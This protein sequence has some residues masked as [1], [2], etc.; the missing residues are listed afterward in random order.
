MRQHNR[1]LETVQ[2]IDAGVAALR[3]TCPIMRHAY[4]LAGTPPL[5]RY[6]PDLRG[7]ARIVVA[8]QVSAASA[9]AIWGR[10]DRAVEYWS[11]NRL[12]ALPTERL[13]ESGLSH[14]KTLTLKAIACAIEAGDLD[15]A[16]LRLAPDE[17][18]HEALTGVRGIGPWTA[19][20]F[21]LFCLGRAD[22]FAPGDLAL[23]T[24]TARLMRARTLPDR[25]KLTRIAERW[26][27]WR[28]VAARL[29]WACHPRLIEQH[30]RPHA[31]KGN[32]SKP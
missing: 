14:S 2:D 7:L 4:E 30:R 32:K 16:E 12:S 31:K 5:R 27:P 10:L 6:T 9:D 22:A 21:L 26:R 11:A 19:D 29:L 13:R 17:K 1:I 28:G 15:L 8:Q 20:I 18:V 23:M 25:N 3:A 24:A